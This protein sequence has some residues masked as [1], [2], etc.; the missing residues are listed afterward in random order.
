VYTIVGPDA[1][2][3]KQLRDFLQVIPVRRRSKM[4]RYFRPAI[5]M[6]F[7]CLLPVG[8]GRAAAEDAKPPQANTPQQEGLQNAAG[9]ERIST[10]F[11][12]KPPPQSYSER[13]V[14]IEMPIS[15]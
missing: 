15:W 1:P 8:I 6:L 5:L 12:T 3:K 2:D 13:A 9:S 14:E 4:T 7:S 10:K 11:L